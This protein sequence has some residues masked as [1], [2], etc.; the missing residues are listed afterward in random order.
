M[1]LTH[2]NKGIESIQFFDAGE[3]GI[4]KCCSSNT[5]QL[6]CQLGQFLQLCN[7]DAFLKC[8]MHPCV[9]KFLFALCEGNFCTGGKKGQEPGN[10]RIIVT[11]L[12]VDRDNES[13]CKWVSLHSWALADSY[14]LTS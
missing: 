7:N 4:P 14:H 8:K 13:N 11:Q 10:G 5:M 6:L 2:E 12:E 9:G 1:E 3:K